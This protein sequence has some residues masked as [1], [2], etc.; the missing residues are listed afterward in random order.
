MTE[1][2]IKKESVALFWFDAKAGIALFQSHNLLCSLKAHPI[3]FG[4]FYKNSIFGQFNGH[5]PPN[6]RHMIY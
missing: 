3:K 5:P 4:Q 6:D 2:E 1:S